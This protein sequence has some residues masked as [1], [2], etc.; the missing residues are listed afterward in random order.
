MY[1]AT[2]TRPI[3]QLYVKLLYVCDPRST[4]LQ[5]KWRASLG[6]TDIFIPRE[7]HGGKS[8]DPTCYPGHNLDCGNSYNIRSIYFL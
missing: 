3:I 1:I 6:A 4:D 8:L 7:A 2:P 5:Q